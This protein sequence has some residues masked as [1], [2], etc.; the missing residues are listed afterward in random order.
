MLIEILDAQGLPHW[1]TWQGM[2]SFNDYS[3]SLGAG[4]VGPAALPQVLVPAN[5]AAPGTTGCR[6]GWLFQNT[7][8]ASML[9]SDAPLSQ[10]GQLTS[11]YL[12]PPGGY[13]P[14]SNFPLSTG[15]IYVQGLNAAGSQAGDTYTCREFVNAGGE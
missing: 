2:D 9:V 15:I 10:A 13:F 3:G 8:Q 11:A 5:P 6:C 14:T 1:V 4:A 7:S 12:V